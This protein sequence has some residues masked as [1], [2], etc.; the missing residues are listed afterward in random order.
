MY[1]AAQTHTVNG[2]VIGSVLGHETQV[3]NSL[4][5]QLQHRHVTLNLQD[6]QADEPGLITLL[7]HRKKARLP[8]DEI[9]TLLDKALPQG[10]LN[11]TDCV[12][13]YAHWQ[14]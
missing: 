12:P 5:Q 13:Y 8:Q 7:F 9:Q 2:R 3:L 11:F 10:T 6:N 14:I 4:Q 1:A